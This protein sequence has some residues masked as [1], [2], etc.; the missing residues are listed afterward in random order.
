MS[1]IDQNCLTEAG[2]RLPLQVWSRVVGQIEG[3]R[4]KGIERG[5]AGEGVVRLWRKVAI[6]QVTGVQ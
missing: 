4:G 5:G 2:P 1:G 6:G 3:L